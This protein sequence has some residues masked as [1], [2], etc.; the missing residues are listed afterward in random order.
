MADALENLQSADAR[1]FEV[2]QHDDRLLA[3][4]AAGMAAGAEEIIERLHAVP[5][6]DDRVS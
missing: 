6:Y 4:V 1:Q 3:L 5:G 2:E